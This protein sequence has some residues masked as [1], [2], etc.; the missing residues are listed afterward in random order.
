MACFSLDLV[1]DICL[2]DCC[3]VCGASPADVPFDDEHVIPNPLLR[4]YD[5]F[6]TP[7]HCAQ[8]SSC[9]NDRYTMPCC[10]ACN[11]LMGRVIEEP[12]G[13]IIEGG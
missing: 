2:G 11:T 3:L 12:S 5:L 1:R 13:R 10:E 9:P 4:R 6:A 7:D 8:R